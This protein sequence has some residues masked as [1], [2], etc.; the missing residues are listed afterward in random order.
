[1]ITE[2][3]LDHREERDREWTRSH[4][5]DGVTV[6]INLDAAVALIDHGSRQAVRAAPSG[7]IR[8]SVDYVTM[9]TQDVATQLGKAG[10]RLAMVLNQALGAKP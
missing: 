2:L 10:V 6:Q 5:T 9:A 7:S 3:I 1:M 8:L 4:R